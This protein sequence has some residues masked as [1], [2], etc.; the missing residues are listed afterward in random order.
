MIACN[1]IFRTYNQEV[2]KIIEGYDKK[3]GKFEAGV[4]KDIAWAVKKRPS[5]YGLG[6]WVLPC[7]TYTMPLYV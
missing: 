6:A 4:Y 5:Q 1:F 2:I 3:V 7:K